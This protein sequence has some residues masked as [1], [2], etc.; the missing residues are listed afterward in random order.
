MQYWIFYVIL[1][2]IILFLIIFW[3][4]NLNLEKFRKK[5]YFFSYS[6]FKFFQTLQLI[7]EKNFWKKYLIFPK[8]RLADIF[9]TNYQK[10]LNKVRAKHIDYL[11]IDTEKHYTPVLAIELN[12]PSHFSKKMKKSD[13]F[14]K[15][16]FKNTW[17]PLIYFFN[18]EIEK[19]EFIEKKCINALILWNNDKF[20]ESQEKEEKH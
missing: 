19:R 15:Q 4:R 20:L 18:S 10:N 12:W 3:K 5:E 7:L 11:I 2:L 14:K 6:E 13:I 16:L 17:L 8:V 9:E 1:I